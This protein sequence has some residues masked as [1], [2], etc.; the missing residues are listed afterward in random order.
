MKN[1]ISLQKIFEVIIMV[2]N[3]KRKKDKKESILEAATKVFVKEGYKKA[4][5]AEIAK[6][7]RSSQVTL[8]K[9]FSNKVSLARAVVIK[10]II[11]GYN[12]SEAYLNATNKTFVEKM[13]DM[14][15]F[16]I[17]MSNEISDDFVV[18]MYDEFSGKNGDNSVMKVYNDNK[19]SFWKKLLDQGRDEG[20]VDPNITDEG[21][22]IYLDMFV[23]HAM[24]SEFNKLHSPVEIKN[25]EDDLMHLFFYGIMGR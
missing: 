20:A 8:Y 4:S 14:M 25:H 1:E 16:G 7:A 21:A 2:D 10:L 18:F 23:V 11:D 22:M 13:Q 24:N 15:N 3:L 9:Y 12:E 19:H 17:S 5:I 6:G